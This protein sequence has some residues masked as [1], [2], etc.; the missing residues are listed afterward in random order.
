MAGL[1]LL[2]AVLA[3]GGGSLPAGGAVAVGLEVE[4][5]AEI[6]AEAPIVRG[7]KQSSPFSRKRTKKLL[8]PTVA[9][10]E[11]QWP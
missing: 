1:M 11:G 3:K 5:E 10:H 4:L 7:R 2:G 8:T 6:G 9:A